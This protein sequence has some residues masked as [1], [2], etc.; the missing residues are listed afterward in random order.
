MVEETRH[1]SAPEGGDLSAKPVS[2]AHVVE[3]R[4]SSGDVLVQLSEYGLA[5]RVKP[6]GGLGREDI[7][8]VITSRRLSRTGKYTGGGGAK[9]IITSCLTYL[10]IDQAISPL[11]TEE[12]RPYS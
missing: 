8:A 1:L 10:T 3:P 12:H 6:Q 11:K 2:E 9:S 5:S 7:V 4:H